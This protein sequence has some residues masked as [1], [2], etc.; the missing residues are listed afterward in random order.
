MDR[1]ND[2]ILLSFSQHLTTLY[3]LS[4]STPLCIPLSKDK[5]GHHLE[6]LSIALILEIGSHSPYDKYKAL[7]VC[8]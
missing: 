2:F 3:A 7:C 8:G 1:S 4:L 5:E 6:L